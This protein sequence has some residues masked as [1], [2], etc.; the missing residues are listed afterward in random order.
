MAGTASK[1][2]RAPVLIIGG[3]P[4]GLYA[5]ALLSR[6]G[7]PSLLVEKN[8]RSSITHPRAHLIN[9]RSME[10]LRELGVEG[11][12]RAQT[13]P[14]EQW[15]HFRYC[16]TLLGMQ[17]AAQDHMA[18]PAWRA[19]QMASPT[20]MAHLSQPKLEAILGAE[21]E[22]SS[23]ASGASLLFGWVCV[24][25]RQDSSGVRAALRRVSDGCGDGGSRAGSQPEADTMQ[26]AVADVLACDGSHS[27][28]RGWLGLRMVGP[29]PL[30]RFKS[31][32]FRAPELWPRLAASP[33]M[34]YFTFNPVAIA[35]FVA[36]NMPEGEWVAQIPFFPGLDDEAALDAAACTELIC[37]HRQ[38]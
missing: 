9:T 35:V 26:V 5:S 31:V 7:V 14:T 3:G 38:G 2:Q 4:V 27:S 25:L 20:E 23:A 10:L 12:V 17:L 18:G 1:L 13:P 37:G 33:A 16:D 29:P 32:H 15:R 34:L 11:A 24:G 21:A 30:Q 6:L 19:L 36:H 28:V 22:R 8:A